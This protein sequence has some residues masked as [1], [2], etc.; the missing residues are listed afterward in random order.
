MRRKYRIKK[1][2]VGLTLTE[3]VIASTLLVI[4]A[5]P[6]LK[7]LAT[8]N[9][10]TIIIEQKS[11]SLFLAQTKLEEIKARSVYSYSQSYSQTNLSL[12]GSYLCNVSD[13][14]VNTNLRKVAVQVGFDSNADSI[15]DS[16]E[17]E[18]T[19]TTYIAKRWDS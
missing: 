18:I 15:L 2:L 11:K 5:V 10:G 12:E 7:G 16:D 3:V 4:G 1:R 13:T 6:I 14:S 8:A 19:L 9:L 17:I